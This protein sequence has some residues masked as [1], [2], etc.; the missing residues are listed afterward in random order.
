MS[1]DCAMPRLRRRCHGRHSR[2][3]SHVSPADCRPRSSN[4]IIISGQDR[5]SLWG[6]S[7][8]S[9]DSALVVEWHAC[10]MLSDIDLVYCRTVNARRPVRSVRGRFR[11]T[12]PSS[13]R[14]LCPSETSTRRQVDGRPTRSE[15]S[16]VRRAKRFWPRLLPAPATP[17][18]GYFCSSCHAS[19]LPPF[20]HLLC[21]LPSPA[22][23][24]VCL[25]VLR[26]CLSRAAPSHPSFP[27]VSPSP[28]LHLHLHLPSSLPSSRTSLSHRASC[29]VPSPLRPVRICSIL[30]YTTPFHDPSRGPGAC[31]SFVAH[32][33]SSRAPLV[34]SPHTR[35]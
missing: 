3:G 11:D 15:R 17:A 25:F 32:R 6:V 29:T 14:G 24:F 26:R 23:L 13:L 33:P 20:D 8:S 30:L 35:Y 10:C 22:F 12:I 4:G 7:P 2:I 18:V 27:A 34:A 5:R 1:A 16:G 9:A 28:L 19:L 31:S 21:P